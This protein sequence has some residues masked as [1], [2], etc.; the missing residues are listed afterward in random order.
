MNY[1]S[2]VVLGQ[3][4]LVVEPDEKLTGLRTVTEHVMPGRWDE[5]RQPSPKELAKTSVIALS[6]A[7]ASVKVRTGPPSEP[8]S[9]D[10]GLDV[11]AGVIGLSSVFD[12]P[13]PDAETER[14][15]RPTGWWSA[16]DGQAVEV[17]RQIR[18]GA[19]RL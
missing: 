9:E 15:H 4:R 16:L 18:D 17:R 13:V 19:G 5:A 14:A 3:A 11:W 12:S 1:R 8:E 6:L 7:E 10:A 2:A